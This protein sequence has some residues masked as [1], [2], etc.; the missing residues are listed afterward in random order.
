MTTYT[1]TSLVVAEFYIVLLQ[2]HFCKGR[3]ERG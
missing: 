1:K 2:F 3:D